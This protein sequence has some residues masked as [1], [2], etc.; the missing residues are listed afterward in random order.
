MIDV[1]WHD[2]VLD[3]DTGSGHFE[4][5]DA[6]G[7]LDAPELHP[8]N[9][10]RVRNMRS[11]L[12]RGPIADR[13]RWRDGRLAT[14][15]ELTA[16]HTPEHVRR[17]RELCEAGGGRL[18][19]ST[20]ATAES[21]EPMLAS[22]GTAI[23]AADA[24]LS[25]DA[26]VAYAL[27][28]PPGH[29]AQPDRPD[30]YCFFNNAALAAQRARDTGVERVAIVDWDVHHGNGT[31]ECFYDRGDVLT[32]SLHMRTG[33]WGA[34]HPQTGSPHEVGLGDGQGTNVNVE[35]P[36]GSGDR[37]Y[38][39]AMREIV[40][41]ILRQFRPGL[42]IGACGQDASAFDPNGRQNVSMDGFRGIGAVMR[43]AARELCDD[44][45][46]LVQEGGYG[47]TYSAYCLHATLEGVLELEEPLLAETLAYM[48]DDFA[49]ARESV[50]AVQSALARY[51]RFDG[52]ASE[53]PSLGIR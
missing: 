48:P 21:W 15:A 23:A 26:Q 6:A 47:R 25:G 36:A 4:L 8:E 14:E 35:L 51:W 27:V 40:L 1:F 38:V 53:R 31:Q 28:R 46:V 42:L 24:V 45:L 52:G 37:A 10:E 39:S 5:L 13:V 11:L 2:A 49:R 43:Q 41:P 32:I 3:H 12:A 50:E 20:V 7:L 30:G 19:G 34:M 18:Y 17:M 16:V 44:R 29:H 9:A 22:A 33:L